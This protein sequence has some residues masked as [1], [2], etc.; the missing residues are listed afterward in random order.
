MNTE[1]IMKKQRSIHIAIIIV[2]AI[3]VLIAMY[4]AFVFNIS[5]GAYVMANSV[6]GIAMLAFDLALMSGIAFSDYQDTQI[7]R[8]FTLMTVT[9]FFTTC[10]S[11]FTYEAYALAKYSGFVRIT[12]ML[13]YCAASIYYGFFWRYICVLDGRKEKSKAL[14]RAM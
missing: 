11:L 4:T 9:A 1:R 2:M 8:I 5:R 6:L 13:S 14:D 10:C 7:T 3:G 12:Y